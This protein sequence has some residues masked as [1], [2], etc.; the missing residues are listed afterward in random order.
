MCCFW[1]CLVIGSIGFLMYIDPTVRTTGLEFGK[2]TFNAAAKAISQFTEIIKTHNQKN[3]K[4][5][6]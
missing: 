6:A 3:T 4:T 2:A 5:T 1:T